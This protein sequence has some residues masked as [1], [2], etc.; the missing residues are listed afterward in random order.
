MR[1][2]RHMAGLM[3]AQLRDV[4]DSFAQRDAAKAVDVWAQD[5]D[6]DRLCGSLFREVFAY[7]VEKPLA[8]TFAI[9]LLFCIKNIERMGDHA[10]NI[11][12]AVYYMS[13]GQM[14][15]QDRPKADVVNVIGPP[16]SSGRKEPALEA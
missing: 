12:E 9:H 15:S 5:A 11:A 8:I 3:L 10:T 2:V 14:L 6:V 7:M 4:L 13:N 1:G 16:A